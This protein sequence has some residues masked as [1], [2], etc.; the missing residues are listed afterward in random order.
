MMPWRKT[1]WALILV[2][3]ILFTTMEISQ[4][5]GDPDR[6]KQLYYDHSCY[7]CHGYNGIGRRSL[8]NNASGLMINE[9]IFIIYL[10]ARADQNP[11]FPTQTMPNYDESSLPDSEARDIYAYIRTLIDQP[12]PVAEIPALQGILDDAENRE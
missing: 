9:E 1:H 3:A 11:Q 5:S 10:R 4:A 12:P 6:G 7:A 2:I 8:A